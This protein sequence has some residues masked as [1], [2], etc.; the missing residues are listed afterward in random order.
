MKLALCLEYPIG[1]RGGV[2]VLVE[3]LLEELVRRRHEVVLVSND[4]PG[5]LE[6]SDIGRRI[7]KH[8]FWDASNPT[9]AQARQLAGQLADAGVELAHF[10][11]GGNFGFGNRSPFRCPISAVHR[12]GIPC[13]TTAHLVVG[14]LDG[15][16]GPRKPLWF[17]L[18]LLPMAWCGKMHQLLHVRAEITVSRHDHQMQCRWYAPIRRRLVQIY[19]SRLRESDLAGPDIRREKVI[20]N[21]GHLAPRKGQAVL[22]EA[23]AE[24][25]GRYLDWRLE[26]AG[27]DLDGETTARIRQL[28]QAHHLENRIVFLG[29]RTEVL[30]LMRRAAIYVQPSFEEALGLAL[31][32]AM[33]CGCAV[34]GSRVGGIPELIAD[35]K[36]GLLVEAG[37]VSQLAA[38]LEKL[39]A[40]AGQ[41]EILGRAAAA[42]I[43]DSDMTIE[44]MVKRHL[45]L[46]KK[47]LHP[48]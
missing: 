22:A 9:R 48:D 21:V 23:F 4:P 24:I 25:A 38:A 35:E 14:L 27:K 6:A 5:S 13:V 37:N 8:I 41:R 11:L 17:K 45:N 20:L 31:Q 42:F 46:Y 29:E 16:C 1:L 15:Y 43:R 3:T 33:A 36:L 40:N 26:L 18:L 12:R 39:M 30:S 44:A 10:H 2:S 47:I 19:H 28:T 7:Q 34:V 32:E